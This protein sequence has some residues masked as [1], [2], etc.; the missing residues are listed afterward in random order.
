LLFRAFSAFSLRLRARDVHTEL[1]RS[2]WEAAK[3][4]DEFLKVAKDDE[5][6]RWVESSERALVAH[7]AKPLKSCV[8]SLG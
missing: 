8:T 2:C 3:P 6:K 4:I 7:A 1:W 5:A